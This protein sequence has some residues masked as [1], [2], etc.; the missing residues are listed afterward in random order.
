[1]Y[2]RNNV[3]PAVWGPPAWSFLD[4][5]VNGFPEI[6]M[7]EDRVEMATFLNSLGYA[8]PCALCR[9]NYRRFVARYPP[10]IFVGGRTRLR[11][12]LISLKSAVKTK[13]A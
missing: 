2:E 13:K 5:V 1:M 4:N 11:G 8:L 6:A 9:K 12:W 7:E 3:A 10:E